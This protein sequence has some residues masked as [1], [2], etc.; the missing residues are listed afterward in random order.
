MLIQPRSMIQS[1][2][3]YRNAYKGKT[4][5]DL[6]QDATTRGRTDLK[7]LSMPTLATSSRHLWSLVMLLPTLLSWG[8][9]KS[10]PSHPALLYLALR[11]EHL[12]RCY[13]GREKLLSLGMP[14]WGPHAT[15]AGVEG[16]SV[17]TVTGQSGSA[18]I[19]QLLDLDILTS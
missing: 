4:I 15:A 7:D 13:T 17:P 11:S 16:A 3:Q 5:F 6:S 14:V 18:G 10:C 19:A 1:L 9:P 8:P 12:G 2:R